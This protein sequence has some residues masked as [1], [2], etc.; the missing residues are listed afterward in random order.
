MTD[1]CSTGEYG[2]T[3]VYFEAVPALSLFVSKRLLLLLLFKVAC[4]YNLC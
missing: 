2:Q 1:S 4:Y 3:N